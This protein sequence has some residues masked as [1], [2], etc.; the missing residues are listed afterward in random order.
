[1]SDELTQT[2]I[3]E[4]GHAVA[5]VRLFPTL[6]CGDVSI[7]P[8]CEEMTLG[9]HAGEEWA[10]FADTPDEQADA[11]LQNWAVYCCAG[12]AAVLITGCTEAQAAQCCESDFEEVGDRLE[13]GKREAVELMSRPENIRVVKHVAK[14]LLHRKRIDGD[15]LPVLIDFADGET[16]AEQYR[17]YLSL[18]GDAVEG[19]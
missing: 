1:M 18:R 7:E 8:D 2:A 19:R 3:H 4:A 14:E 13:L 17:A 15:H 10:M 12:Y 11:H 9:R 6:V 16:T 5:F